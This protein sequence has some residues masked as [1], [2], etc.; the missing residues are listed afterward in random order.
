MKAV[1]VLNCGSSSIKFAVIDANDRSTLLSGLAERLDS[2]EAAITFKC[3]GKKMQY[4]LGHANHDQAL[5]KVVAIINEHTD[6][7]VLGI[8]HRVVHGG[9]RFTRSCLIDDD[10]I[11]GIEDC[12]RLAPLHNPAH[13]M[14]I[15]AARKAYPDL[16]QVAVF[17]TAFHQTLP[18]TAYL[19]ALPYPYY[20]QYGVRRYGFHGTSYR[21]IA[22]AMASY[23]DG[24]LPEKVVVAH[25]G[26]GA[27]VCALHNG[28]SVHTSMGLTPLDGLVQGTRSGS[29]DPALVSFLADNSG[30]PESAITYEL[31]KKSGLL[32]LS[33]CTNDCRELEAKAQQGD[34]ACQRALDVFN[35]RLC[36]VIGSFAATLNGV[37]AIVFTG[38]IGE[39]SST[40]RRAVMR[41][42][43][44]LGFT[45]DDDKNDNTCRGRDG[46]IASA[47]SKPI[48]VIP[49]DEE[50][51]IA[52]DVLA[53]IYSDMN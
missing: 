21:Y 8:G 9:E 34:V 2:D 33:Q 1:L 35:A 3:Q 36:E 42:F 37:D 13:L 5:I 11:A 24:F 19:Y 16:P 15:R 12:C 28:K 48:W 7:K 6:H 31:W 43:G 27:S 38:G 25:L 39:N 50:G 47:D 29:I 14:G 46:N 51:M 17:D 52:K 40:V 53:I 45:I 18:E 30:K 22:Q 4:S 44:Y 26:N 10:V 32:G 49:T 23:N 20:Q 41:Q